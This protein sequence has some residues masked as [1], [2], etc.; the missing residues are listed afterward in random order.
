[1]LCSLKSVAGLTYCSVIG[2][3]VENK[4]L[5]TKAENKKDSQIEL[6]RREESRILKKKCL[7]KLVW[8]HLPG[9][10]ILWL[11]VESN[12]SCFVI[13]FLF[14]FFVLAFISDKSFCLLWKWRFHSRVF[15]L[16]RSQSPCICL[17]QM[18]RSRFVWFQNLTL[19]GAP[20]IVSDNMSAL[21]WWCCSVALLSRAPPNW[22][23]LLLSCLFAVFQCNKKQNRQ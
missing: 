16:A 11:P 12:G 2:P 6:L 14:G 9:L 17:L 19:W 18:N 21:F 10:K 8:T 1:M 13:F 23:R 7:W 3:S 15:F 22:S 5:C 4:H 20:E